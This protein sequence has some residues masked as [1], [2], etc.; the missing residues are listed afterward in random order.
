MGVLPEQARTDVLH[1]PG[2][3]SEY[4]WIPAGEHPTRTK[5]GQVGVSFSAHRGL[6]YETADRVTEADI[7][8][9]SV[10]VTGPDPVTWLHV[11]ETTE[12]LEV[13]PDMEQIGR[14]PCRGRG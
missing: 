12:A 2:M 10:F 8:G 14:A 5:P 13:Y 9:G 11:G 6:V 4:A 3:R 7:A 1:W